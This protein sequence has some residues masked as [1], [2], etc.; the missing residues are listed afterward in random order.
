MIQHPTAQANQQ[1]EQI[2]S[3][4]NALLEYEGNCF[5]NFPNSDSGSTE[6][7]KAY[8]EYSSYYPEKFTLFKNLDRANYISLLKHSDFLIGNSSSGV[9]EVATLGLAAINVGERQR[10]RVHG[11]NIIFTDNDEVQIK[12]AIQKV[13]T[14]DECKQTVAKK[15][16]T[17]G[18]GNSAN[19]VVKILSEIELNDEL[20]YKNIT[21]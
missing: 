3:T 18:T 2:K 9:I 17:Y 21:Y 8:Q 12:E 5:I 16:N 7:I 1:E 19:Y 14:D 13:L 10:G 11:A 4:L 6:I 15:I 20:I